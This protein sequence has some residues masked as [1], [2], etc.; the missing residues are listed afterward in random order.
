M[1][2]LLYRKTVDYFLPTLFIILFKGVLNCLTPNMKSTIMS[3]LGNWV[4]Y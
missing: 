2:T 4:S 1:C 3:Y